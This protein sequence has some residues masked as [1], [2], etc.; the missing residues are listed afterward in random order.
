MIYNDENQKYLDSL[1]LYYTIVE[2]GIN[3]KEYL[4]ANIELFKVRD[5]ERL[6][7]S[8]GNTYYLCPDNTIVL[9]KNK[10]QDNSY[11]SASIEETVIIPEEVNCYPVTA[12]E[13]YTLSNTT[14]T[15]VILP[16]TIVDN[17]IIKQYL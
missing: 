3:D 10:Y 4:G 13:S 1:R 16:E 12:I 6:I 15:K 2:Y 8:D 14:I 11:H 17:E 9:I 5:E 7:Q